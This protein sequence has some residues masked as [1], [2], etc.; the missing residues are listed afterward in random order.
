VSTTDLVDQHVLNPE[1]A[2]E[3]AGPSARPEPTAIEPQ[4]VLVVNDDQQRLLIAVLERAENIPGLAYAN[5]AALRDLVAYGLEYVNPVDEL[6]RTTLRKRRLEA[7]VRRCNQRIADL[8]EQVAAELMER[9]EKKVTHAATGASLTLTQK[10]WAKVCREGDKATDEEKGA[11]GQALIA[12]GLG[13]FVRPGFNSNSVSAHFREL[14]N[15]HLA[16]QQ[17]LPEHERRPL[18]V[19]HF[20]PEPL[21]GFIELTND[22]AISVRAA[23]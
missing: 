13:D 11:A 22:P 3:V 18:P 9:G 14:Y 1:P 16:E 20:L 23:T 19:E 2:G 4:R 7:E 6:A 10:V 17:A 5:P 21:K 8:E 15:A 12:A